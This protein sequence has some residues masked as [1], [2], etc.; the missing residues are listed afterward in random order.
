M[1]NVKVYLRKHTKQESGIV[2]ISF[3]VN[4][5]K[6]NFSTKVHVDLKDWNDKKHS[7]G[8]GDKF[9]SD[10]NLIIEN[11]LSR[12]NNV[13]VKYRLKD[14]K[15]SRDTFLRAYHRPSDYAT[16]FDFVTEYSKKNSRYI[17]MSTFL[18]HN[19][20]INKLKEFNQALT[21]DDIT[22]D[23]LDKYFCYLKKDLN[24]NSNTAYKNMGIIRKYV[25][26]A[27]KAGYLDEN[28]FEEWSIKKTTASCV[29]LTEDELNILLDKYRS[30]ELEAK[31]H[32]TLEFFLFLCFSSLHIG[33]AK[34]LKL[35]QFSDNYFTYY[36]MKLKNRK[37]EPIVVPISAP[38]RTILNN[39][40][41]VRK[42]GLIFEKIPADQT[43][44]RD[45]KEIAKQT[46][47]DKHITHK[48][49]R[50]TFATIFLRRTK[51]LA[52]LKSILGHSDLKETMIYAHVMD[53][54]KQEGILVFNSFAV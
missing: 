7:V 16:F 45:L 29:Y 33:D 11:I 52:T 47:I 24:N 49:G 4:R 42:K 30:G 22:T 9:A 31:L 3:Y 37:P 20:V 10:K 23:F 8:S 2:W 43:M 18:T 19:T 15:I 35:E 21:F 44:N 5:E 50:H 13:L 28:P 12:I 40:V 34:A 54:S 25:R 46:E 36:R 39:I 38:L 48:V 27:F 32:K 6:V 14:K 1:M 51:D 26:A 53:E 41:G 17:E